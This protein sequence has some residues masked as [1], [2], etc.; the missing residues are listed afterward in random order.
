MQTT[1]M[2][3]VKKNQLVVELVDKLI[4]ADNKNRAIIENQIVN[5]GSTAI[6]TLVDELQSVNGQIR[7]IGAM[8]LIRIGKE[9]I[10]ELQNMARQNKELA[11]ISSYIISEIN[12]TPNAA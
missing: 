11:W 9:S 2:K 7:G 4:N 3:E 8:A 10:Y 1:I 12:L 6:K 5:L